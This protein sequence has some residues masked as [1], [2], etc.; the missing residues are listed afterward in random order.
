MRRKIFLNHAPPAVAVRRAV[1]PARAG[2]REHRNDRP[3]VPGVT[4][5][6]IVPAG[7]VGPIPSGGE[8]EASTMTKGEGDISKSLRG[9]KAGTSLNHLDDQAGPE[10]EEESGRKRG[11]P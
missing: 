10:K 6:R 4:R 3:A 2:P 11:H 1:A 5:G 8:A 7:M 9:K